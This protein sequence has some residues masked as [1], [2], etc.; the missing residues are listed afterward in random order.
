MV[1]HFCSVHSVKA[2]SQCFV[3]QTTLASCNCLACERLWDPVGI[4][5]E[6]SLHMVLRQ[7]AGL[8]EIGLLKLQSHLS[9]RE[10]GIKGEWRGQR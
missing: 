2:E 7:L 4:R 3:N 9:E 8:G 6:N 10:S 5:W 1:P